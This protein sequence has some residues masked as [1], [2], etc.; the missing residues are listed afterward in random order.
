MYIITL[1]I[2]AVDTTDE[3]KRFSSLQNCVNGTNLAHCLNTIGCKRKTQRIYSLNCQFLL[4]SVV[5]AHEKQAHEK[6][7][8]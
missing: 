5:T 7:E 6:E 1:A 8:S 4:Y 3:S 2:H